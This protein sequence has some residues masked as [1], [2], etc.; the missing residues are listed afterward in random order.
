MLSPEKLFYA[1]PVGIQLG[2]PPCL[3]CSPIS[4][5][6]NDISSPCGL[7]GSTTAPK[8]DS[9]VFPKSVFKQVKATQGDEDC[10]WAIDRDGSKPPRRIR[11][12][13]YDTD[14]LCQGCECKHHGIDTRGVRALFQTPY[15]AVRVYGKNQLILKYSDRANARDIRTF[16]YFTLLKAGWSTRE[17]FLNVKLESEVE[18]HFRATVERGAEPDGLPVPIFLTQHGRATPGFLP[19]PTIYHGLITVVPKGTYSIY[20]LS[21]GDLCAWLFPGKGAPRFGERT[22][23]LALCDGQRVNILRSPQADAVN[24]EWMAQL[25]ADRIRSGGGRWT[26]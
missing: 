23:H 22:A 18:A 9:H 20:Q 3:P 6:P 12:G 16:L 19:T 2:S 5:R 10:L 14:I 7:C 15:N 8:A 25:I 4:V 11:M 13:E 1:P 17:A 21:V 26:P 24:E